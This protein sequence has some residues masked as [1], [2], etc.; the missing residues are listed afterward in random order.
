LAVLRLNKAG[1]PVVL[2]HPVP[3]IPFGSGSC[4]V[5]SIITGDCAGEISR[6]AVDASLGSSIRVED[7]AIAKAP[8][9]WA[10]SFENQI[11]GKESCS[12]VRDGVV[13]YRD[14]HHLSIDG[15]LLLTCSFYKVISARAVPR[16]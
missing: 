1:V 7:A 2:V 13:Q 12:T 3:G 14:P 8:A 10:L 6:S 15:A 5:F 4:A 9:A 11:C 16:P